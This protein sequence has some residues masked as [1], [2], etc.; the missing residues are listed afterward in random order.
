MEEFLNMFS[1]F[2]LYSIIGWILEL[3]WRSLIEEKKFVKE[4]GFLIGPWCPIYGVGALMI[5]YLLNDYQNDAFGLFIISMVMCTILEYITSYVMEKMFG[6]RWWDYS[7]YKFNINGRICLLNTLAFGIAAVLLIMVFHPFVVYSVNKMSHNL[8]IILSAIICVIFILDV[9]I[10]LITTLHLK[11]IFNLLNKNFRK[12]IV[13]RKNP[14][15]LTE[16]ELNKKP[17]F[18]SISIL[19]LLKR[20]PNLIISSPNEIR[21]ALLSIV[22]SKKRKKKNKKKIEEII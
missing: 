19:H 17:K 1:Y 11:K 10:T 15:K 13:F 4:T 5:I 16:V 22:N 7:Q 20:F 3:I 6:R 9:I 12:R 18:I 21:K 14:K 8:H 2:I